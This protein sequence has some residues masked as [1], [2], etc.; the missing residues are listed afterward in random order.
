MK[1][2]YLL[3]HAKSSWDHPGLSDFDRPLN[4]RGRE[5][6]FLMGELFRA[7]TICPELVICSPAKRTRQTAK[8]VLRQ[9]GF[10][11]RLDFHDKLYLA[12]ADCLAGVA[13]QAG[14][15]V[16]RLLLIGHNPGLEDLVE[17]LTGRHERMPTAALAGISIDIADWR[18][19]PA[20]HGQLDCLFRPKELS[21]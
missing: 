5:A 14:S 3:R 16:N 4:K 9:F 21:V 13:S 6:A 2:L 8:I 1:V 10:E 7:E 19:L 11:G 18:K 17:K 12:S 15:R 20:S